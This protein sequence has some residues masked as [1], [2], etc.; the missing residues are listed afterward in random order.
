VSDDAL[1]LAFRAG[2]PFVGLRDHEHDPE[3]DRH[4]PPEAARAVRAVPL[5]A[6]DDHLLLAVADPET[7]LST[8]TPYL[9]GREVAIAIAPPDEL[10]ALLGPPPADGAWPPAE[11]EIEEP[12]ATPPPGAVEAE[13]E[14]VE[15]VAAE[16]PGPGPVGPWATEVAPAEADAAPPGAE[17]AEPEPAVPGVAKAEAAALE[18]AVPGVAE[19]EA[20]ALVPEDGVAAP[21]P[22]PAA[23]EPDAEPV[24]AASEPDAEPVVAASEPDAA[25]PA[26]AASGE[27]DGELPSWLEPRRTGRRVV[28]ALLTILLMAVVVAGA[29]AAYIVASR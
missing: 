12:E 18:P 2:L 16:L 7:D 11:P 19:A 28:V 4:I 9:A 3:L 27:L 20:A 15:A 22:E 8:L 25:G 5:A 29:V 23:P 13:A 1:A 21:R 24:V 14:A 6:D 17:R 26:V 10:G